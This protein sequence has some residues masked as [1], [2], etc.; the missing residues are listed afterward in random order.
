[1]ASMSPVKP[2]LSMIILAAGRGARIGIPKVLLRMRDGTPLVAHHVAAMASVDPAE[3]IVVLGEEARQAR[4]LIPGNAQAV[5]NPDYASG[6]GSS[7]QVGLKSVAPDS[8][9]AVITLVD[10]TDIPAE[11]YP[12]FVEQA[13]D[14]V[15]ARCTWNSVP[16][17][18][19]MFGHNRI[20]EAID[21]CHDDVGA[22]RL[23]NE[24]PGRVTM[25]ESGD[26]LAP[27]TDGN[28][29]VDTQAQAQ[30]RGIRLPETFHRCS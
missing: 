8:A 9:A 13:N 7:L 26:L 18:P 10:L 11:V 4:S 19:V 16:G 21:A 5:F 30:A 2:H 23:F 25:I 6:M 29:D 1:M 17:H 22:K 3:I 14:D 24:S 20:A 15:I 12:R 28:F 27:G